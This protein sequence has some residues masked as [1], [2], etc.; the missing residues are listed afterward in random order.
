MGVA[1]QR[2]MKLFAAMQAT[3]IFESV[4]EIQKTNYLW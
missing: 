3:D 1:K 2:T 4:N